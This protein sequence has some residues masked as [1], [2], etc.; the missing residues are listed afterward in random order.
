MQM[1]YL[2]AYWSALL[3]AIMVLRF[4]ALFV[5]FTRVLGNA[6]SCLVQSLFKKKTYLLSMCTRR[7][8]KLLH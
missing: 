6:K 5:S 1:S 2:H 8:L 7:C 3:H 4:P